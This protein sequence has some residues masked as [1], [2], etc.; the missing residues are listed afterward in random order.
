[1][2]PVSA[3]T[4][5]R[6]N[7]VSP[8][9]E[10]RQR[11]SVVVPCCNEAQSLPRL[12]AALAAL[13]EQAG[14]LIAELVFVDDG[15]SDDTWKLLQAEFG[16]RADVKLVQHIQNR[17]IAAAIAT[18]IRTAGS[19]IVCSIDADCT[20]DPR[21]LLTMLPLLA[22]GVDLV[23]ASP[24]HPQGTVE[25]VP[26]WRLAISRIASRLYRLVM[27]S[28]L[29]TY[30]SCFRVYRRSAV[31]DL[32]LSNPGFVGVVEL[33]WQLDSGGSTIVECPARLEVRRLGQSK[34]RLLRVTLGH[35]QLLARA[36][37]QRLFGR[38]RR[39]KPAPDDSTLPSPAAPAPVRSDLPHEILT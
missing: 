16:K 6:S 10:L 5:L 12:T 21:Q 19:Q 31:R 23:V 4:E 26:A 24:Y 28:K 33:V 2:N 35:L 30:T 9:D 39:H 17:G 20:Y 13:Q 8:A 22:E 18:G 25:N 38:T 36:A 3:N 14:G 7:A 27:R 1:V 15:S 34:M 29:H 32:P 37:W 11:V